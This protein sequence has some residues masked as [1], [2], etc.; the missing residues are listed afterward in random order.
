MNT[1]RWLVVAAIGMAAF[2]QW[3]LWS[4]APRALEQAREPEVW[5]PAGEARG[6]AYRQARA[7]ASAIQVRRQIDHFSVRAAAE[8]AAG[9]AMGGDHGVDSEVES[10]ARAALDAWGLD[11]PAVAV[12]AYQDEDLGWPDRIARPPSMR[13]SF[14]GAGRLDDGRGWCLDLS[15]DSDERRLLRTSSALGPSVY[16]Q[17]WVWARYGMPGPAVER[18]MT[19][20]G[21]STAW[22]VEGE[23]PSF[24]GAQ[25]FL[26][27]GGRL[28]ASLRPHLQISAD[29]CIDGDTAACRALFLASPI[30][31]ELGDLPRFAGVGLWDGYLPPNWLLTLETE[32]GPEK[33]AAFWTSEADVVTAFETAFGVDLEQT[34][35][36]LGRDRFGHARPGPR[37]AGSGWLVLIA[38][39]VVGVGAAISVARGRTVA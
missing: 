9:R 11:A 39:L 25:T 6:E 37:L 27:S 16:G 33:M 28:T 38:I 29:R 15:R 17:C 4:D 21:T 30:P 5:N 2:A 18:W 24:E 32:H 10:D 3:A 20:V 35:M 23:G 22:G 7:T 34:M 26:R 12:G 14:T 8:I 13:I 36:E 31:E 19:T 1:L